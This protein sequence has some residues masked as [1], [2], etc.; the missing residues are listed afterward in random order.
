MKKTALTLAALLALSTNVF[1][2]ETAGTAAA[3]TSTAGAAAVGTTTMVAVAAGA[4]VLAAV[5][6][7]EANNDNTGTSTVS[8]ATK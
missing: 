4:A 3:S 1:A 2:A 8:T 7:S 6:I 5:V